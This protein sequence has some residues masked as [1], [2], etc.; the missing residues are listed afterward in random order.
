[1]ANDGRLRHCPK[2]AKDPEFRRG[3]RAVERPVSTTNVKELQGQMAQERVAVSLGSFWG[4][5]NRG[6]AHSSNSCPYQKN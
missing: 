3:T 5:V 6:G 2:A 1:M 4:Y